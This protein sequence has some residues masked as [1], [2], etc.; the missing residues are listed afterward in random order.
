MANIK[1]IVSTGFWQDDKVV[2]DFSPEDKYFMLY[3]LTNPHTTQLGI[4]SFNV[5]TAAFEMGYSNESVMVL[6]DRFETKYGII[7]R[8]K[9]TSEIAIKNYLRYS[10]I[11]GGKPVLD[12]LNSEVRSVKD[13]SLLRFIAESLS[14]RDDLLDTVS[15]FVSEIKEKFST[16]SLNENDNENDNDN[17][18]T[19]PVRAPYEPRTEKSQSKKFVPPTVEQVRQYCQ[20]RKNG[21]DAEAFVDHYLSVGWKI[22]KSPMKDW[23]AAVRTWE[24]RNKN[25]E[26]G[27]NGNG[28]TP[29]RKPEVASQYNWL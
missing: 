7:L 19:S 16:L 27:G 4:Y 9:T 26:S 25:N 18:S 6:L 8:S 12:L 23:K 11:K 3:L 15:S 29:N 21:I 14:E 1:R 2:N 20:E 10:V 5:K 28:N 22:N 24:R 17:D 13:K